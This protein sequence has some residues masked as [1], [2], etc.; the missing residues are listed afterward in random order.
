MKL[1]R[2]SLGFEEQEQLIFKLGEPKF[3]AKQIYEW[4]CRGAECFDDMLNVP[5]TLR[6]KL[7]EVSYIGAVK[8]CEK[9][10]SSIDETRKY[11]LELSDGNFVEA[12]LMK[13]E[14]G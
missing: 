3:R 5:K 14:H 1:Q 9:Y 11:L 2:I 12:V 7:A 10:T 6:G 4:I 8:I 13:Y